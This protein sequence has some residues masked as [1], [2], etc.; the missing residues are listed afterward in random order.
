M[1]PLLPQAGRPVSAELILVQPVRASAS[2]AVSEHDV[3]QALVQKFL[4]NGCA[5]VR[6]RVLAYD[7][8][9]HF[10]MPRA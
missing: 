7:L 8:V 3:V 4:G 6:T 10:D 2:L 1:A 9:L 5:M